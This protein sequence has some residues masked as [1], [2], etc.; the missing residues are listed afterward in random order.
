M[1]VSTFDP[2]GVDSVGT[3]TN[4]FQYDKDGQLARLKGVNFSVNTAINNS[5]FKNSNTAQ[6]WNI[7]I[8]YNLNINKTYVPLQ[9]D[10]RVQ[11]LNATFSLAPTPKWKLDIMTNYDFKANTFGYTNIRIYR[12]LHCWEAS[13]NWVPFG[14]AKQYSVSLNL[15]TAALR[16]IKIPK[17]K[18]WFD[19]L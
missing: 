18:Q 1:A 13:I 7:S 17:Q 2:Y 9:I 3:R 19:N 10:D 6:P 14:F 11:T 5:M 16:D 12:D 4:T 15:K 8:N